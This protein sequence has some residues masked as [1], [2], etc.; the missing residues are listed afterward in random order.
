MGFKVDITPI[1]GEV[2]EAIRKIKMY[3]GKSRL[4]V[5]NAVE[6]GMKTTANQAEIRVPVKSGN[7][8]KSIS[9]K[10]QAEP[11]E[12][13]VYARKPK[14]SHAHLVELGAKALTIVSKKK[15]SGGKRSPMAFAGNGGKAFAHCVKIKAR[16]PKP[17]LAPAFEATRPHIL[18]RVRNAVQP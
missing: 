18:R 1:R 2:N 8:K 11:L 5:E 15:A 7:L 13:Y 3:D 14:G 12:A 4:R 17:F 6:W 16:R 10:F 9:Q